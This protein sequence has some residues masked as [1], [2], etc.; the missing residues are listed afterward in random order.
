MSE[1]IPEKENQ[2]EERQEEQDSFADLF[3]S[4]EGA[5]AE[6][7]QVGDKIKGEI[8]SIGMDM[9]FVNT[10][11]KID[12]AVEKTELLDEN[13]ELPY[14]VGD[15]LELYVVAFDENEIRLSRA[16]SGIGGLN[17]LQ[18][19]YEARM[20]VEGRVAEQVKGGFRIELMRHRAFC[21]ISQIDTRYVE[22]ADEYI[23]GTY[24]FQIVQ[25]ESRGKNIVVSRRKLMEKEQKEVR[26]E[27]L[28]DLEVDQ[29]LTGR[30]TNLMP[31]GAFVELVPG[32]EG[33]VHV[34]EMSWSRVDKPDEVVKKDEEVTVRVLRIEAGKKPDEPRLSLSLKQVT[35][36]PWESEIQ[37]F[38]IGDKVRGRVT[39][40]VDF[41]AFVEIAHGV[42]GL[43][44][45]SE[46][47][48]ARRVN[49]PGD[50]VQ[51]NENVDVMIKDMDMGNRRI[52]LSIR[53]AEG[54]PWVGMEERY[55]IGQR[56][57]GTLENKEQFGL[58]ISLEP[59]ITGL[60]PRSKMSRSASAAAL[61]KL[62]PGDTVTVVVEEIDTSG[63]KVT[64]APGDAREEGNWKKYSDKPARSSGS[65]GSLGE[66]LKEALES[67]E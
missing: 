50:V 11:S 33:M 42:E 7:I 25:F 28:R 22:N 10:G 18:D 56:V 12:G 43:V 62:N 15:P 64:L 19:A 67:K 49:R 44:H 35:G 61:D 58:F 1:E 29:V 47:S 38:R 36:D 27:F 2:E 63:R 66:K 53:D 48:Y 45:I 17:M 26:K 54:D 60:L 46:M 6:D 32:V 21:P 40:L 8:I 20:P 16:L 34:S 5:M 41:G 9:V 59:G 51:E 24:Q 65:L 55:E 39:R 52:S 13:G 23:G 14:Q 3:A 4:Y 37:K 57:E 30:V 31:Y